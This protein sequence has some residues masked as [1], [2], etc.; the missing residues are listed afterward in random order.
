MNVVVDTLVRREDRDV[1]VTFR[2]YEGDPVRLT[3]LEITG[4][5]SIGSVADLK[6][7][8]PLQVGDPFNRF[9]FQASADTIVS[10]LRNHGYPF[11]DVLRSFDVDVAGVTG[12]ATLEAGAGAPGGPRGGGVTGG[13]QGGSA[14]PPPP[15]SPQPQHTVPP[16]HT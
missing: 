13:G 4:F 6:R 15:P 12:Q 10:R 11:G 2:I 16:G 3:K 7:S 1:Y 14:A 5:D 8:L 9:L